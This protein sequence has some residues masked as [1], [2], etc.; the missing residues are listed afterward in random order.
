MARQEL[1][2]VVPIYDEIRNLTHWARVA[3]A[4]R[5]ARRVSRLEKHLRPNANEL[6]STAIEQLIRYAEQAAVTTDTNIDGAFDVGMAASYYS[7]NDTYCV[8]AAI[9]AA[10]S[11]DGFPKENDNAAFSAEYASNAA[12]PWNAGSHLRHDFEIVYGLAIANTWT[13]NTPVPPSV[14]GPFWPDGPPEG[15]PK[16]E[17]AAK[18]LHFEFDVPDDMTIDDAI[19]F[20]KQLSLELCKLDVAAGGHGVAIQPPLEMDVPMQ[21]NVPSPQPV[22]V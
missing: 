15:W 18:E 22:L 21:A 12:N 13:D 19:E 3:F 1:S 11:A 2:R 20:V 5:C 4:A 14:F 17:K 7:D 8:Q 6:I 9:S 16:P 10:R